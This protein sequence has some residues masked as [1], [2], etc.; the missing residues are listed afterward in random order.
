M[1]GWKGGGWGGALPTIAASC[2]RARLTRVENG[3]HPHASNGNV[4]KSG[5]MALL[6]NGSQ[7]RSRTWKGQ[8]L[9]VVL[10]SKRD[11]VARFM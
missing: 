6:E 9:S 7:R 2:S 11:V 5:H 8:D 4:I 10:A 1:G 3:S